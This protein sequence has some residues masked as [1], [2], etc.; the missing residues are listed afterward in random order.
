ELV[1]R[2]GVLLGGTPPEN[3]GHGYS[4]L[5]IGQTEPRSETHDEPNVHV[6]VE[7]SVR[8]SVDSAEAN[9]KSCEPDIETQTA[10]TMKL[11]SV[12]EEKAG[13]DFES[14][15]MNNAGQ[16]TMEAH[17][18][19]S[20]QSFLDLDGGR[21]ASIAADDF[22]LDLEDDVALEASATSYV[23]AR[24]IAPKSPARSS[25]PWFQPEELRQ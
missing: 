21:V 17:S 6:F 5:G 12:D 23:A 10:D 9:E 19:N 8:E 14:S 2:V 18:D 3:S 22:V 7:A 4:T 13:A 1:N 15:L 11:H 20:N 25:E 16:Q 24:T